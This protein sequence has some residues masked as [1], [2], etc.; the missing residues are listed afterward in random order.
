SRIGSD[1]QPVVSAASHPLMMLYSAPPCQVGMS[2]RVLFA[3]ANAPN[4]QQATPSRPCQS[5]KSENF[6]LAG[7]LP[8][9]A[10]IAWQATGRAWTE[11]SGPPITFTSGNLGDLPFS[12]A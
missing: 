11:Q 3:P 7:L 6:Y 9:T 1:N 10:Y 12:S 5:G 2:V 8:D 4:D